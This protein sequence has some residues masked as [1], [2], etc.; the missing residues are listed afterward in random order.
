MDEATSRQLIKLK[1]FCCI[2]GRICPQPM[3]WNKLWERLPDR[4]QTNAGWEPSLPLILGAWWPSSPEDKR[5]RLFEHLEWAAERGD[6][7]RVEKY[8]LRLRRQDWFHES[9]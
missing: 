9:D 2:D 6:L 3:P 7:D 5:E 4:K 8:L 1:E